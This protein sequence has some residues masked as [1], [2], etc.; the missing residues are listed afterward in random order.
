MS[1]GSTLTMQTVRLLEPQPRTFT[2]KIDQ[3]LKALKLE[4]VLDK[5]AILGV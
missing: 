5:D 1:G 3:I 4:R 2:A